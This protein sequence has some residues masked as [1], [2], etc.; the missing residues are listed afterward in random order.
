MEKLFVLSAATFI[1]AA[2]VN[3]QTTAASLQSDM[4][5]GKKAGA[6]I[7]KEKREERKELRQLNGSEASYQSKQQFIRDFGDIPVSQWERLN[8]FDE[9][10][11]TKDGHVMS[12]FYDAD[13]KLVGTTQNKTF[14]D[15]PAKAQQLIN[16]NYKGYTAG[17]VMFFDDNEFN[18]TDM[19]LFGR[20]FDDED[21]YFVEMSKDNK[22]IVL[23]VRMDG[24]VSYFTRLR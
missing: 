19:I 17:E 12:A 8:N 3:A 22:K 24:D 4:K 6:N 15:L 16:E 11:F 5:L 21:S 20:Q 10:T 1:L 9:A 18:Q 23:H 14:A 2:T 7:K 13:A